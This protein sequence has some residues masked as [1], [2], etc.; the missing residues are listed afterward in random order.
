MTAD[1]TC[2]VADRRRPTTGFAGR[3]PVAPKPI[4]T[5]DLASLRAAQPPFD[6]HPKVP[7]GTAALAR[8]ENTPPTP[9]PAVP[10]I[11]KSP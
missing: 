6:A 8:R 10:P 5:A 3:L 1:P 9:P 2:P 11:A 4:R 7:N